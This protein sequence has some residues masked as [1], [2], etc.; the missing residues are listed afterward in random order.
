MSV[1]KPPVRQNPK[2]PDSPEDPGVHPLL[3]LA[4]SL[5]SAALAGLLASPAAAIT[6]LVAVLGLFTAY[7]SQARRRD[8]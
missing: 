4:V 3:A 7:Y 8:S 5:G 6:V 1:A 2:P